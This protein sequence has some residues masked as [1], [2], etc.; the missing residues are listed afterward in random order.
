MVYIYINYTNSKILTIIVQL[1]HLRNPAKKSANRRAAFDE[2]P[3]TNLNACHKNL[4]I[5]IYMYH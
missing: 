1:N 4:K 3:T 5:R 2:K